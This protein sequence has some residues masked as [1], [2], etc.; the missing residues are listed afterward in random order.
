MIF[1]LYNEKFI[2][3]LII[4][5]KLLFLHLLYITRDGNG[6]DLIQDPHDLNPIGSYL[7]RFKMDLNIDVLI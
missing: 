5:S 4:L 7:D 1:H 2:I 6:L 3:S